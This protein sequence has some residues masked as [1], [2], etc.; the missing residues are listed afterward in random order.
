MRT[1]RH[2]A[3]AL[4]L[5]VKPFATVPGRLN[6]ATA[7]DQ[8][9]TSVYRFMWRTLRTSVVDCDFI[10]NQ[11]STVIKLE[12]AEVHYAILNQILSS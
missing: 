1:Q 4:S 3:S 9:C 11:N 2:F 5:P 7:H 8:T 6:P 10:N 12:Y